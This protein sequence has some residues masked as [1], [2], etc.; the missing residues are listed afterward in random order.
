MATTLD[1]LPDVARPDVAAVVVF[2]GLLTSSEGANVPDSTPWMGLYE[3]VGLY[4]FYLWLA[5]L[6][7]ILLR[8]ARHRGKE[9]GRR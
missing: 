3:R 7:V 1:Q 2:G 8:E 6:A 5:V 4:G 9:F